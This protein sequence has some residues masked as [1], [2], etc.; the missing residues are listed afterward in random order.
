MNED[1]NLSLA[2]AQRAPGHKVYPCL[3]RNV[4][5]TRP[6]QALIPDRSCI[7]MARE[8][9][10][11]I[12]VVAVTWGWVLAR[13]VAITL[14]AAAPGEVRA[15]FVGYGTPENVTSPAAGWRACRQI[16][17]HPPREPRNPADIRRRTPFSTATA[18]PIQTICQAM[19]TPFSPG[20]NGAASICGIVGCARATGRWQTV[21]SRRDRTAGRHIVAAPPAGL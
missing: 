16:A 9:V 5:I 10:C 1:G 2:P 13:K 6:N 20:G 21:R 4:A 7:L 18:S 3:P 8:F 14:E 17:G 15:F 19:A 12:A 11:F